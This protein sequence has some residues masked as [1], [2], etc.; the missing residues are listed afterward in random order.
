M[1]VNESERTINLGFAGRFKEA[2]V[3]GG[4]EKHTQAQVAQLIDV[5]T[6]TVNHYTKGKRIPAMETALRIC[7]V[8]GVSLDWLMLGKGNPNDAISLEEV[9][10]SY[11]EEERVK[12]LAKL[13]LGHIK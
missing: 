1:P 13:A 7:E 4:M 5:A 2:L 12:L 11:P 9:W 3:R 6:P 10:M 8:T